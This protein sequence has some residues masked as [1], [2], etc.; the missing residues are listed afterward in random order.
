MKRKK[1]T[2]ILIL[3]QLLGIAALTVYLTKN[4]LKVFFT[5]LDL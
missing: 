4:I 1:Q 5:F 2:M 3:L